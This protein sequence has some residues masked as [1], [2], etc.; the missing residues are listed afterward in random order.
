[1][2]VRGAGSRSV[3]AD[4]Y[5]RASGNGIITARREHNAEARL[6]L[7]GTY[8]HLGVQQMEGG[9]LSGEVRYRI[10][11]AKAAF[12]EA[13]R[14]IYRNGNIGIRRKAH[15]LGALVLSRLTQGAGSW[16]PLPKK[17]R[18][19]LDTTLWGF[20]RSLLCIPWAGPQNYTALSVYALT[21]LPPLTVLLRKC[22]LQYLSQMVRS[23]PDVLWAAV[24]ADRQY[25][26]SLQRDL[27]WMFEWLHRTTDLPDPSTGWSTWSQL[28]LTKPGRFKGLLKRALRLDQLRLRFTAALDGLH[29]AAVTAAG[30]QC[31]VSQGQAS[32]KE[33]CIPCK[34]AFLDR[35]SWAAHAARCHGYRSKA[36]LLSHGTTCLTCGRQYANAGRLK[37][38]LFSVPACVQGWGSFTPNT[39]LEALPAPHPLA[40][41]CLSH[42]TFGPVPADQALSG[43]S[44]VCLPLLRDLDALSE[45]DEADVWACV[46][47]VIEPLEV[48]RATV[49]Q[50]RNANIDS[51]WH[52]E[53]GENVLLLLD[54][55]VTADRFPDDRKGPKATQEEVPSWPLPRGIGFICDGKACVFDL[56]C[57]P[58]VTFD[59]ESPTSI[60]LRLGEGVA[61]W[62]ESACHTLSKCIAHAATGPVSLSCP[63]I[64][65]CLPVARLWFAS[66]GF[67]CSDDG[68]CTP[69]T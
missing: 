13:R 51:V 54:P 69:S 14:K 68:L 49:A 38:H 36:H 47:E 40:P 35:V 1:M 59:V 23:G 8:K 65:N 37:R 34:R 29:R 3:K 6:P 57:P 7:V 32:C 39:G 64:W 19:V 24:R 58:P 50:W 56:V 30:A 17:D 44:S 53:I 60:P 28:M 31:L 4:L 52:C 41:P 42:G 16:P 22:R 26:E 27:R 67:C 15:I 25:A 61:V 9:S 2:T 43:D 66:M 33:L 20:Y 48:L 63:G 45:A 21:D 11:Q 62:V 10:A 46:S 55:E 18:Q 12:H 5:G